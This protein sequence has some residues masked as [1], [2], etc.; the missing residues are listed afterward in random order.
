MAGNRKF[1]V[2]RFRALAE[3]I[4]DGLQAQGQLCLPTFFFTLWRCDMT[5]YARLGKS[6]TGAEW[7]KGCQFPIP[8][9]PIGE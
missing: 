1:S 5:A 4:A 7:V 9:R 8:R 3:Y 6:L 2:K